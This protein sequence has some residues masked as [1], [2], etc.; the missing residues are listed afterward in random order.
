MKEGVNMKKAVILSAP[1][2]QLQECFA[3][4][5]SVQIRFSDQPEIPSD[6]DCVLIAQSAA[7]ENLSALAKL[8]CTKSRT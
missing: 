5:T 2:K 6:A 3:G 4:I 7:Y 8:F 1:D